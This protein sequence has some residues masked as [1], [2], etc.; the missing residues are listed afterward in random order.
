MLDF[1]KSKTFIANLVLA[2]GILLV[3]SLL[4]FSYLSATTNHGEQIEVPQLVGKSLAEAEALL[5]EKDL[6]YVI[7]DSTWDETKPKG[8]VLSQ[9]PEAKEYVKDGRSIY[10]TINSN[11][12]PKVEMPDLVNQSVR[13]ATSVLEALGLNIATTYRNDIC[14]DCVLEQ[15]YNGKN[16]SAG[17]KVRK[18]D[19]ITLVLGI[20]SEPTAPDSTVKDSINTPEQE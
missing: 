14:T 13:Q 6:S 10:I 5:E 4:S 17:T 3:I 2:L 19:T 11:T 8:Y 1:L 9:L 20:A 16:I 7:L 18:G 12:A 15:L